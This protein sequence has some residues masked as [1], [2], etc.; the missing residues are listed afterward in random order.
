MRHR[1]PCRR[2]HFKIFPCILLKFVL[3]VDNNQF[4]DHLKNGLEKIE[5]DNLLYKM[6]DI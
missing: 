3:Y 5:M 1:R 4:L 2:D 6:A